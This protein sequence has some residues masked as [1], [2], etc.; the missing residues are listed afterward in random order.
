VQWRSDNGTP[1]FAYYAH[2]APTLDGYLEEWTGTPYSIDHI[3][4]RPENWQGAYDLSAQVF[5]T[6]DE[7]FFYLGLNVLD[8]VYVQTASGKN[9]YKG[10]DVEI[11]IDANLSGDYGQTTLSDDDGQI[12]LAVKDFGSGRYEAYIWRPPTREGPLSVRLAARRTSNP[13]GY[14]LE[15][16][17]PWWALNVSPRVETPFGFCLSLADTDTPGWGEQESMASTAPNRAWGDPTT[18]GTLILVD[19]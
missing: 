7:E 6:W 13:A 5:V 2:Q 1:V 10:D 14:V 17:L 3:V 9:L 11:Q 8:D 16:A 12:G 19:W 18:W 4:F 15:V